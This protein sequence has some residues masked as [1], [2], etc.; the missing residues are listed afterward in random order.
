MDKEMKDL[1]QVVLQ[2]LEYEKIEKEKAA[3]RK[4]MTRK[5]GLKPEDAKCLQ[6]TTGQTRDIVAEKLGISGKHW[7]RMKYIY[8][9]RDSVSDKEYQ[10]WKYAELSTTKLYNRLCEIFDHKKILESIIEEIK[11]LESDIIRYDRSYT[12]IEFKH[13]L[14][15]AMYNCREV[16]KNPVNEKYKELVDEKHEFTETQCAKMVS[17]RGRLELLKDRIK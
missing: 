8:Y 17:V 5:N 2:G 1:E 7:E 12:D 4:A 13:K 10:A 3:E 14:S 9:H 6:E 15:E 11:Y 16:V